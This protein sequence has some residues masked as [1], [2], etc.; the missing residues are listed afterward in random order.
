MSDQASTRSVP[1]PR[2]YRRPLTAR[3]DRY[4]GPVFILPAVLVILAFSIFP[5][6]ASLYVSLSRLGFNEGGVDLKFVGLDNYSKLLVGI[7][8]NHF[9][10][11]TG[12]LS[13]VGIGIVVL[14]YAGFAYLLLRYLR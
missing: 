2:T 6:L 14:V 7:D 13:P 12:A 11:V 1:L 9:L 3:G 5:L 8:H 4:A 10:G